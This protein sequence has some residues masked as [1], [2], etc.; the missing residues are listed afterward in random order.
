MAST[1][2]NGVAIEFADIGPKDGPPFLFISGF[3]S[4][5]TSWPREFRE[6]LAD[7]GLRVITFDN[8]DVGLSQK[9]DGIFPDVRA[10]QAAITAGEKPNIPYSLADM[11]T[12]GA[13]LLD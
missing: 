4:Q 6:G 12:D 9:W 8:R 7:A 10:A 3:G 2:A 1:R 13:A 11:A 5:M